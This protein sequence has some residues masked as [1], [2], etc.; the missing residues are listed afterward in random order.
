MPR[1]EKQKIKLCL[2]IDLFKRRTDS[3][4]PVSVSEIIDYLAGKGIM[5]ERKSIYRD[6][7]AMQDL[8]YEVIQVHDKRFSYYLNS[9][10]FETAELRLLVD[11]V[12]ASRFITKKKSGELIKKLE[13]LTTEYDAKKLHSQV[14]VTNRVKTSNESIYYNVDAIH[15][16]IQDNYQITFTYFDWDI[17]KRRVYRKSGSIY[18]VSPWALIWHLENYYLIAYD[19]CEDMIKHYR[20]DRMSGINMIEKKRCGRDVF[21]DVDV[22]RYAKRFFGMYNGEIVSVRLNCARE[23]T[24][25]IIDMFGSEVQF[26]PQP[27][28]TT[29][30]VEVEVAMSPVFLSWVFMFGGQIKIL[31]PESAAVE[32]RAMAEKFIY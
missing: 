11:A 26:E 17:N 9:R 20:V 29:F 14:F 21:K 6:I 13:A 5:S 23:L 19:A 24:N 15:N 32:L 16:A 18:E 1:S 3:E 7:S 27:D 10:P 28:G 30:D 31:S 4:H 8:G 2:I 12:Q 22:A 25:A